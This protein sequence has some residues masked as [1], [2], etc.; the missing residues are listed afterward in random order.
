M[1]NE[2]PPAYRHIAARTRRDVLFIC[3]HASNHIPGEFDGLGLP[4]QELQRHIAY[5]IGAGPVTAQLADMFGAQA[6]LGT[7]SRLVIDPN[8]GLDDPTLVMRLSDGAIVPGNRELTDDQIQDRID[9]FYAPYDGAISAALDSILAEGLAPKIIS[10]HSFTDKWRG[11][12]RHWQL[13]L[14][15]DR[16]DRLLR[17]LQQALSGQDLT[18]GD[19][20]PYA[21]N[22]KGDCLYRHGTC[23][24]IAHILI[25]IRQD[26]ISHEIGV[27]KWAALLFDALQQTLDEAPT[28]FFDP[29]APPEG[30]Y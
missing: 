1:K 2:T 26:L 12:H 17:R 5:D 28:G 29:I 4:A 16:D 21:G 6:I 15:W 11:D 3:D 7:V 19:N 23:R 9:R 8:R 22:L 27:E 24:G 14:L 13:G 25:E 30:E 18:V 20:E 10:I